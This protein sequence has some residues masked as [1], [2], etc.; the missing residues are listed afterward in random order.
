MT[1]RLQDGSSSMLSNVVELERTLR[2]KQTCRTSIEYL[3]RDRAYH[4]RPY[5]VQAI[6]QLSVQCPLK[7]LCLR[8]PKFGDLHRQPATEVAGLHYCWCCCFP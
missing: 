6:W 1:S 5:H 4:E 2:I 8:T 3:Q 7:Q